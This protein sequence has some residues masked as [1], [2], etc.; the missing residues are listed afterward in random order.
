MLLVPWFS[1]PTK[2][3][4][5]T[6]KLHFRD[7]GLCAFLMGIVSRSD[8]L[9]SPLAGALWESMV[10]GELQRLIETGAAPWQMAF[11]RDRTKEA[12][13]L[14]HRAG[15]FRLADAKWSEHPDGPGKLTAVRR[16][17]DPSPQCAIVCRTANRFPIA[18]GIEALGLG[19]LPALLDDPFP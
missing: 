12:D 13:F 2:T 19:D 1:K 9:G 15:H 14:L 16:E 6:P 10:C 5:K 18:P 17:F 8:L 3:L 4:V 7:T 11:W